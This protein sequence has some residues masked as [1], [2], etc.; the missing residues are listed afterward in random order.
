VARHEIA[1]GD[2][3][4]TNDALGD[5]APVVV[6]RQYTALLPMFKNG[7]EI[8]V[9][10]AVLLDDVTAANFAT[11]DLPTIDLASAVEVDQ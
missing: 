7:E 3:Q 6:R 11:T 1:L 5:E 10:G 2:D 9:G 4:G 8:P